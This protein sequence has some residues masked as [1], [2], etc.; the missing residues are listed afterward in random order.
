MQK[1]NFKTNMN[2]T[3][4]TTAS[5]LTWRKNCENVENVDQ[6]HIVEQKHKIIEK[7][8]YDC[9]TKQLELIEQ[10]LFHEEET[11]GMTANVTN[12]LLTEGG[13]SLVVS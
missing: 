1:R 2:S 3:L 8:K 10:R 13:F 12:Q 9:Q 11:R 5:K 4:K 7:S 6:R